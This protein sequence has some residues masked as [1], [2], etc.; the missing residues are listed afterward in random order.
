MNKPLQLIEKY[1]DAKKNYYNN[2]PSMSDSDYDALEDMIRKAMPNH[3][4]LQ[5]VGYSIDGRYKIKHR[6]PMRSLSKA[7]SINDINKWIKNRL[8]GYNKKFIIEDKLDGISCTIIYKHGKFERA[9]SRGNGIDGV[10]IS[11]VVRM[12]DIPKSIA[13]TDDEIEIRGEVIIFND[14]DIP[15]PNKTMLRN[16]AGGILRG[17]VTNPL[18][19]HLNFIAY[20]TTKSF[21]WV[22]DIFKFFTNNDFIIPNYLVIDSSEIETIYNNY[23]KHSRANLNYQIDGLVIMPNEIQIINSLEDHNTHH[24]RWAIAFKFPNKNTETVLKT[25]TWQM[26]SYGILTPVG[27]L[28]SVKIDGTNIKR[29]TLHNYENVINMNISHGDTVLIA[30]GNDVIPKVVSNLNIDSGEPSVI[31]DCPYCNMPIDIIKKDKSKIAYCL[32]DNCDEKNKM[33]IV[34]W[35]KKCKMKGISDKTVSFLWNHNLI[36]NVL[37]LYT[38]HGHKSEL[39]QLQGMGDSKVNNLL[40][41]IDLSRKVSIVNFLA[42]LGIFSIDSKALIK[43]KINSLKSFMKF[44]DDKYEI[45]KSI[46]RW[47]KNKD[48]INYLNNLVKCHTFIQPQNKTISTN[49]TV[50]CTGSGPISRSELELALLKLGYTLETSVKKTTTLLLCDDVTGH[51]NKLD[52]ARKYNIPIKLYEELL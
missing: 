3:W 23:I 41:Q 11:A 31:T 18:I 4:A 5:V 20:Q 24:P 44:N 33:K 27:E 42:R 22:S 39:L 28:E 7:N 12:M 48:N 29:A 14:S 36:R 1:I 37:D 34:K 17:D 25:I 49:K 10:D 46:I 40:N 45:G 2:K 9:I 51:S 19:H 43:L 38:L 16:I 30:K 21:K 26:S 6:T 32:N 47:K 8:M 15:N 50:V 35:V 52:K 13:T